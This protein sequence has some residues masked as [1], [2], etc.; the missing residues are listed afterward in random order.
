MDK[1]GN[2]FYNKLKESLLET[3]VFPTD[4][5]YKFII[6]NNLEQKQQL[7]HIF[8]F[9]GAVIKTN[10]SKSGKFISFTILQKEKSADAIIEKY[11]LVSK[12]KNVISL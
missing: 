7:N 3:T 5:M 6:P 1:K 4:Y 11:Q 9:E 8:N 10:P 2:D 12:I